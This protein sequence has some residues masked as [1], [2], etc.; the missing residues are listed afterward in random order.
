MKVKILSCVLL[1]VLSGANLVTNLHA[2]PNLQPL[3]PNIAETGSKYYEFKSQE[4]ISQDKKRTYQVWLG[5]PKNLNK[6]EA[7]PILYMIDGNSAMSRLDDTTLQKV[8]QQKSLVLVAVGYKTNLPFETQARAI[9]YTPADETG[10]L[11]PD[12][13]SPDRLSGGSAEFLKLLEQQITPWVEQQVK[14][15][16]ARKAIWG[17]SYGGLFVLENLI[18]GQYFSH[19]FSASP[20]LGWADQRMIKR[21]D[22]LNV[23]SPTTKQVVLMEGDTLT[24]L[25]DKIGFD[26]SSNSM[27][28]LRFSLTKFDLQK[29]PAKLMIYPNLSH[30][31]MF[32]AS[33]KDVLLNI[34]F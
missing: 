33:L 29:V 13:K 9:D 10:K 27:N 24:P 19:Y 3:G 30:G 2:R 12:P 11:S 15:E 21:I 6:D 16:P 32:G 22:R 20:S 17:H 25:E 14:I 23:Q 31:E 1:A 8:S 34:N 26:Y 5:V 28:N 7:A 18:H 4:F